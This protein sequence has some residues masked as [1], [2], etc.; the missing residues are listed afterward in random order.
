[1]SMLGIKEYCGIKVTI[2]NQTKQDIILLYIL[3]AYNNTKAL[4]LKAIVIII[5]EAI[6]Y[7][8]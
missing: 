7:L 8:G 2:L 1:M 3:C 4:D 5:R 6:F